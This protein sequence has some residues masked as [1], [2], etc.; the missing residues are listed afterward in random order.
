VEELPEE[1]A[2]SEARDAEQ[3]RAVALEE[4]SATIR[5]AVSAAAVATSSNPEI[6][7]DPLS[8]DPARL[9]WGAVSEVDWEAHVAAVPE[10]VEVKLGLQRLNWERTSRS[11]LTQQPIR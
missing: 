4:Y 1:P 9:L 5:A 2:D 10:D 11:P 7:P 6:A 3:A 8:E